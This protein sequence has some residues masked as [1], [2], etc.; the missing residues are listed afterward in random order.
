MTKESIAS[1]VVVFDEAETVQELRKYLPDQSPLKDFIF[2]NPLSAFQ[3]FDFHYGLHKASE[4]FGYKV[5]L[6]LKKFRELYDEKRIREDVLD[7]IIVQRKGEAFL[8]FWKKKLLYYKF[9]SFHPARIGGIRS[10]WKR[11]YKVDLDSMVHPTLYKLLT[12]YLDQGIALWNF[13][14]KNAGLLAS[15]K[16]LEKKSF[17]SFFRTKR[18][19]QLLLETDCQLKDLLAILVGDEKL[20]TQYLFDQQFAHRGWSGMVATIERNPQTLLERRE[21][22]LHDLLI[23]DTLL[24]IDALDFHFNGKWEPLSSRLSGGI[25]D[26]FSEVRESELYEALAIF[27]EAFEWTYYDEVLAG[28]KHGGRFQHHFS[29]KT[30]QALFCI[31]DREISLRRYIESLEPG[32]ETFGTPGFFNVEFYFQPEGGKFYSKQC[33]APVTPKYLIKETAPN[34]KREKDI[35]FHKH[36]H[37]LFRGWFIT[38]TIGFWSAFK[39][40]LNVF[41]PS[42]SPATASSLRH[43]DQYSLLTVENTDPAYRENDLQVGFSVEEMANRVE[44]L[45]KSIGLVDNFAPIIYV[46]GHGASS[47]NNPYYAT[48]DCGACSCRPGSVNARVVS[49]MGNHPAVRAVLK[50][51][52]IHIP[53]ETQFLGGLHDTTRDDLV[54]FDEEQLT[55]DNKKRHRD[56]VKKFDK[57]LDLNAK[58]RS[59]RFESI[60]SRLDAEEIHE[61]VRTR[62]VSL[63]EPR[64]ELDHATNS[65]CIVGRRNL[66]KDLFLDRRAFLN[67]YN[68]QLDPTGQYLFNILKA[69]VPV[70][71]GINLAYYFSTVDN[72]KMGS[73]TKLPHNVMGLFGVA[74]GVD[75]DLRPGLPKQM[76]E[77][78]D[79]VRMFF[80]VEHYPEVVLQT[81]QKSADTY[82]WFI[83]NWVYLVVVNPDT[84]EMLV[85]KEGEFIPYSTLSNNI[86]VVDDINRYVE[87]HMDNLPVL[88]F[89]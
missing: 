1:K 27:H 57:A 4:M 26:L 45:L 73:G 65:L 50:E 49:H 66:T 17:T 5:Y 51:R 48:M 3:K 46:I 8:D 42:L 69:A 62:S 71:G 10:N 39:L 44:G 88:I 34:V 19:R 37:S 43:M 31:D 54:F 30:F 87:N 84:Q 56:Y 12:S 40:F 36:S 20:Y 6:S 35:H 18:A 2:L 28:I 78:H 64:P 15:L 82:E 60:D 74:N 13:P 81:I 22:H 76:V 25:I 21:I 70:C 23:L 55:E 9:P 89:K 80:V 85:F 33:P 58:E 68:Y 59:R 61:Q 24:E 47:V 41:R 83:N 32:C 14:V 72:Q 53:A 7:R 29:I 52:G 86:A 63:F 11:M 67:S 16:M 38:Q 79:P 77:V 75:G